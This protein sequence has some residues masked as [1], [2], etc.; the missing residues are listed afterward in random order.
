MFLHF[1]LKFFCCGA[2]NFEIPGSIFFAFTRRA[3]NPRS[4]TPAR[5]SLPHPLIATKGKGKGYQFSSHSSPTSI[6]FFQSI[7]FAKQ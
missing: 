1:W 2:R 6:F 3:K 4:A 7:T 5:R